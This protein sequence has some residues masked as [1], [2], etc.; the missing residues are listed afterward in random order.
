M[1]HIISG[2][3]YQRHIKST[4]I[5]PSKII[6]NYV[7]I[8]AH[9][10]MEFSINDTHFKSYPPQAMIL[11]PGTEYCIDD[12]HN[13]YNVDMLCFD[14]TDP[15][16]KHKLLSIS[17]KP[18]PIYDAK[19]FS[20]CIHH[21]L[22]E[23]FYYKSNF[24]NDNNTYVLSLLTNHLIL[25]DQKKALIPTKLPYKAELESL[26]NELVNSINTNYSI[27][28]AAHKLNISK[29]YFQLLYKKLFGVSYNQDLIKIRI[30]HA[31]YLV[32]TTATPLENIATICGYKN[33]V[34][35]YRQFKK[36]IGVTP[37][38]FRK[39]ASTNASHTPSF[40]QK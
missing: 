14:V 8:V 13:E 38:N 10:Y 19:L 40:F 5:L 11:T 26:R 16:I 21:I 33:E 25:C 34:H 9:T 24:S 29:S 6:N 12:F 31:K 23:T 39:H 3:S 20:F 32:T 7:I 15:N 2:E 27:S 17:N 36:I 35:F 1:V 22:L 4:D 37:G 18:I 28:D 30:E